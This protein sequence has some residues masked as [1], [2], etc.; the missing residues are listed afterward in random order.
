MP[1]KTVVNAGQNTQYELDRSD[2]TWVFSEGL[3]FDGEDYSIH[4]AS[5]LTNDKILINARVDSAANS[6]AGVFF[7]GSHS[8]ISVSA[9]GSVYGDSGII[10]QGDDL[11]VNNDGLVS[12]AGFSAAITVQA[13]ANAHVVNNGELY[14]AGG[15]YIDSVDAV[16][17]NNGSIHG[18]V[19]GIDLIGDKST[20]TLGKTSV[21][22]ALIDGILI[23]NLAGD[24]ATVV[25]NGLIGM[26]SGTAFSSGD[27][28]ETFINHGTVR[29]NIAF[30]DGKDVFNN[31]DG[32]FSGTVNGGLGD[33]VYFVNS[34]KIAIVDMNDSGND[35]V[36]SIVSFSLA[37]PTL[38][39]ALLENL[40]LLG[41]KNLHGTGN[42]VDNVITGNS[43]NNIL[44]A[45]AGSDSLRGGKGD[46]TFVFATG[47]DTDT[48][49]DFGHGADKIDLTG[50]ANI[51][52]FNDLM[53]HH[54]SE[55]NGNLHIDSGTD[56]L[57]LQHIGKADLQE[58]QFIFA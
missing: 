47:H 45:G 26:G 6:G 7:E 39:N 1:G 41:T 38:T 33:D 49:L 29:G 54:V 16:I 23:E 51:H 48:V 57:I 28:N 58:G 9:L 40:V 11:T 37:S 18:Y 31:L 36:K 15:L 13:G 2:H 56:E 3:L 14:G 20:I 34:A 42:A 32:K 52:S 12:A 55:V 50:C 46:D 27:G 5:N 10:A 17:V 25:N 43:G 30:G 53:N 35:T 24:K 44:D 8:T 21:V 4:Q 19:A 22:T